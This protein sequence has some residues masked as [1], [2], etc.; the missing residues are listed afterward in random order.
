MLDAESCL[1]GYVVVQYVMC[2]KPWEVRRKLG[3]ELKIHVVY[4]GCSDLELINAIDVQMR[5]QLYTAK[6]LNYLN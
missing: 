5:I 2:S 6:L 1:W 4:I 3:L